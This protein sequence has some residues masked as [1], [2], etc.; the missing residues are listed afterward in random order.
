MLRRPELGLGLGL[1]LAA[2]SGSTHANYVTIKPPPAA[3]TV[4]TLAGPLCTNGQTCTCRSNPGDA[5]APEGDRKRFEVRIGPAEHELWVTI[6]DM[7]L[8]KGNARAEDCFYLDLGPGDHAVGL[9]AHQPGGLSA[10]VQISEYAPAHD[11]WYETYRFSCGAPGVCSHDEMDEYKASLPQYKRGI[12]DPCGSV[13]VKNISWDT[14]VAPDEQH[15]EDL[16]LGLTLQIY[17]FAPKHPHGDPVC[18]DRFDE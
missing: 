15:P 5:G 11:S 6:D 9:R 17:P 1:A 4:A 12:H 16:A 7:V 2:C 14:G 3:A 13:K 10:A 18:K 8:Y